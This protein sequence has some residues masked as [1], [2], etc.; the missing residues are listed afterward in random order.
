MRRRTLITALAATAAF[1]AAAAPAHA[2]LRRVKVTLVT[3]QQLT[4]A[5]DVPSGTP[6]DQMAFTGLPAEV[7]LVED[8]GPVATPTPTPV[9]AT[10]ATPTPTLTPAPTAAPTQVLTATSTPTAAP[11]T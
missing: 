9:T 2:E 7:Q 10:T 5:V 1:G 4:L 3:G 11:T 6:V 8:L